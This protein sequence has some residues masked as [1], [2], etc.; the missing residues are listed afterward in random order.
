VERDGLG[1]V[2]VA[3]YDVLLGEHDIVEPDLVFVSTQRASIINLLIEVLSPLRPEY[4]TQ[5]K[6]ARYAASGVPW[7]WIVDP[8]RPC[9]TELRLSSGDYEAAPETVG[10]GTF[11]SRLF[12]TL[13]IPL[14]PL[15]K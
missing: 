14:A 12:P 10:S 15:W 3:P 4:D 11:V 7:Y 5:K 2:F 9:V 1:E 13:S 8:E 6:R